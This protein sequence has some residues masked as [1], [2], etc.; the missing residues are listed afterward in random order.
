MS[1]IL[2]GG[3]LKLDRPELLDGRALIGGQRVDTAATFAPTDPATGLPAGEVSDVDPHT[4]R[5]AV[6]AA[7]AAFQAWRTTPPRRRSALLRAWFDTILA[8]REDLAKIIAWESGKPLQEARDEIAYGASYIEW[9]AEE[10]KRPSG[11]VLTP[12]T[13]D[14]KAVTTREPVGVVALVTPWNFPF[15]MIAR[16]A[17]PALAAGCTVVAKPAEDTPLT[18]LAAAALALRAGLPPGVLNVTPASR[19]STPAL[20]QAWMDDRRVRKI[21]FTGSTQVGRLLAHRASASLKRV[22]LE[23]GGDA[24][25]IVFDDADLDQAVRALMKAKFRNAGQACVAANRVYVQ[26]GVREALT[27]RL[28]L[29]LAAMTVGAPAEGPADIGPLINARALEKVESLVADAVAEGAR[30]LLGGQRLDRPGC[31]Y[32]PTLVE[33]VR[34]SMAIAREEIFGP[35]VALQTFA[36]EAEALRLANDTDYGLAAYVC[37]Q[38]HARMWRM[39]EGLEV[40]MVGV[41]EGAISSEAAPF[42]GVKQ[43][44]YGRE[45]AAEGLAEY[46]SVKYVCFG[47][48]A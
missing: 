37:T 22:S 39:A 41:N 48:L 6:D 11:D 24:P 12:A 23:L 36:D 17:A 35:V 34:P 28:I 3:L 40:G 15:A 10:I 19:S 32:P 14:R 16:K 13:A 21:S 43:S 30:V 45:G 9:Y 29:A 33:A 47:G 18:T 31:F 7:E 44:G 25:F 27:Q 5:A 2:L 42:G 1:T 4:A 20:S 26:A 46:Q 8:Q 38:D